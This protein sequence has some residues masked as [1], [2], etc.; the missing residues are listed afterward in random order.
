MI[1]HASLDQLITTYRK[2]GWVLR[3]FLLTP[4]LRQ[5][6]AAEL[7][8][9]DVPLRSSGIDAAWFSRPPVT[10]HVAWEIRYLGDIPFA[11][12]EHFDESD[13]Q[14]ES[15]LAEVESKLAEA[16]LAKSGQKPPG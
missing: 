15:R 5:E 6:L 7:D 10:G 14:F 1:G 13:P 2:H 8:K 16:I 11:L 12:L 3:Q 9:Y 4:A